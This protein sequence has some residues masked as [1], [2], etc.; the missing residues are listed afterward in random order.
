MRTIAGFFCDAARTERTMPSRKTNGLLITFEGIDGCGKSTQLK[1]AARYLRSRGLDIATLREPGSTRISERIRRMLLDPRLDMSDITELL[2][3]EAA[4]SELVD[5]EIAPLLAAGRIV[6][7]DRY[8]DSTTAYQG[9]GR[10]LDLTMVRR[11]HEVAVGAYTPDLTLLFDLPL[12]TALT[13]RGKNPDRLES[14]SLAFFRRVARGFR[15]IARNEPRRV[16]VL[17]ARKSTARVFVAVQR[18]LDRKLKL[19]PLP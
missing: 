18:E 14:Q 1:M 13:R 4:R 17:D 8:Y 7:C 5:K 2:L 19:P 6:L 11:L 15:E 9:Y 16:T 12:K 3:Y 10:R